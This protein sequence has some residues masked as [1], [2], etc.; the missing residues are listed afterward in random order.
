MLYKERTDSVGTM[1]NFCMLN[2]LVPKVTTMLY[3][4]ECAGKKINKGHS[5]AQTQA[6]NRWL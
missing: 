1:Q 6:S 3:T 4:I 2:V 5:P